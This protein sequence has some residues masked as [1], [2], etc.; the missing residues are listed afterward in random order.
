MKDALTL[1]LIFPDKPYVAY[2]NEITSTNLFLRNKKEIDSQGLYSQTIFGTVG[3]NRR[4]KTFG[5]INLNVD[6]IHPRLYVYIVSLS[7]IYLKIM[8]GTTYVTFDKK[9]GEFIPSNITDGFTGYQ[10]F[11]DNLPYIKF[12]RTGSDERNNKIDVVNKYIKQGKYTNNKLLVLPAGLRDFSIDKND[13]IEEDEVNDLYRAVINASRLVS[14]FL[15][16]G[17]IDSFKLD[18]QLKLQAVY[19]HIFY[20]LDGKKKFING[21]FASRAVEFRSR[22]VATGTPIKV[23]DLDKADIEQLNVCNVGITQYAKAI[24]PLCKHS[25]VNTFSKNVFNEEG[26]M[27]TLVDPKDFSAITLE[28]P[29]KASDMWTTYDGLDSVLNSVFD[30]DIKNEP[31][32]VGSYL[33]GLVH[34]TGDTVTYYETI[35]LIPND[36]LK[37]CRGITYGEL[38]HVSV[39]EHIGKYPGLLTRYPI[40]EQGSIVPVVV[41][42]HTTTTTRDVIFKIV[43]LGTKDISMANY[44]L[45]GYTWMNSLTVPTGRLG[46]LSGDYDGDQLALSV[47]MSAESTAEINKLMSTAAAY[48]GPDGDSMMSL[49]D[50][51]C[52]NVM[53]FMTR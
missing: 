30:T 20:L 1:K 17:N 6:V 24:D 50:S 49:T 28:V 18:I 15:S 51:V 13:R 7:S 21:Q 16:V 23:D 40:T 35:D 47:A 25:I 46:G 34:D 53:K 37:E 39:Y 36:I 48:V 41:K 5:Y 10:Y 2:L 14:N 12:K 26:S 52:E 32:M 43:G 3:S 22:T 45:L 27:A 38:L 42:V 9:S 8:K 4:T 44:P 29:R 11:L 19:E 31:V 33:F